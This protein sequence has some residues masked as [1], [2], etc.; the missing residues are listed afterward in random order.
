MIY[1]VYAFSN[2]SARTLVKRAE[3]CGDV[4]IVDYVANRWRGQGYMVQVIEDDQ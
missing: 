1:N 4:D 3:V 2:D